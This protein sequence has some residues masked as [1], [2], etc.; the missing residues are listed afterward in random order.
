MYNLELQVCPLP[1]DFTAGCLSNVTETDAEQGI[2]PKINYRSE[3]SLAWG[4]LRGSEK[5]MCHFRLPDSPGRSA[6]GH[7]CPASGTNCLTKRQTSNLGSEIKI[8]STTSWSLHKQIIGQSI[9]LIQASQ[10]CSFCAGILSRSTRGQMIRR[11]T[12]QEMKEQTVSLARPEWFQYLSINP[13]SFFTCK[14]FQT[15]K[16]H[17]AAILLVSLEG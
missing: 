3:R 7:S 5:W 14:P 11:R 10:S 8:T 2:L 13:L 15:Y 4:T 9:L 12:M 6:S 1:T 17:L 16:E